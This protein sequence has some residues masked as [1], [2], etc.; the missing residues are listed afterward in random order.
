MTQPATHSDE[1]PAS[2]TNIWILL[3][4]LICFFGMFTYL[5][6]SQIF[7][8]PVKTTSLMMAA[9]AIPVA[10]LELIF[11][12]TFKN[13]SSGL[14]WSVENTL[15]MERVV[16]KFVGLATTFIIIA[17]IYTLFKEY[18]GTFYD[19]F[20]E[21]IKFWS[22]P[23]LI[24]APFYFAVIDT[25][26][27]SPKDGYWHLGALMLGRKDV[28]IG[29]IRQHALGWL[30]K[31]FFLPMM[32][33]YFSQNLTGL[34][35]TDF[36]FNTFETFY[37]T[38]YNTL[39]L[40]DVGCIVVGYTFTLRILDN[41]IRT[42]EPTLQGWIVAVICYQPFWGIIGS[43]YLPYEDTI[44]WSNYEFFQEHPILQVIFGSASLFLMG[45]Y[46]WA[47]LMFG[48]RFSNMTHRGII[49][50]GPY[51]YSRHP[52][53]VCK[54]LSW[55]FESLPLISKIGRAEA[56]R[57]ILRLILVN[58]IYYMRAKTEERH[59][60]WDPKYRAYAE[61][62]DKNGWLKWLNKYLPWV[63]FQHRRKK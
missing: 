36:Q 8:D 40:L 23:F 15:D 43:L 24:V 41:H 47:S 17:L 1:R 21:F 33:V 34:L 60:S 5:H 14:N 30:V 6:E 55:W 51:R 63:K 31:V 32:Y 45:I 61:W 50:N 48:L 9:Y 35:Q 27:K 10:S 53:Y 3:S 59:L 46:T 7:T 4:G 29:I 11:L 57:N 19:P 26:M 54:N 18:H 52:A 2:V 44:N 22:I 20:Y 13:Q 16:V 12:K 49:T 39:I 62:M 42:T 38:G 58:L 37:R 56:I 28:H 25:H